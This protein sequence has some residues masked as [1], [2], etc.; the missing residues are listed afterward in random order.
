MTAPVVITLA[1]TYKV[2]VT[3][4]GPSGSITFNSASPSIAV[5]LSPIFKGPK[6]DPGASGSVG[7]E[8][9]QVA[10]TGANTINVPVP[11]VT[12]AT[13]LFINGLRQ[14]R[15]AY[16]TSGQVVTLP[17]TLQCVAGDV[18]TFEYLPS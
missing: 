15:A 9:E 11:F 13:Q 14:S 5:L 7:S 6:G 17:T 12:G 3:L 4:S 18:L 8:V 16:S 2:T 10:V 1:P